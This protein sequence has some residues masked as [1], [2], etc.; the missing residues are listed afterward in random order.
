ME[1]ASEKHVF[2]AYSHLHV[3]IWLWPTQTGFQR[4]PPPHV[5]FDASKT[6]HTLPMWS[7]IQCQPSVQLPKGCHAFHPAQCCRGHHC[8]TSHRGMPKCEC[9]SH[10]VERDSLSEVLIQR[11]VQDLTSRPNI[12]GTKAKNQHSLTSESST[13]MH[14]QIVHPP[15]THATEDTN[16]RRGE[17]IDSVWNKVPIFLLSCLQVE[18][19]VCQ[20][21]LPSRDSQVSFV[22][23]TTNCNSSTLSFIR[24]MV[25]FS[26]ID[27]P[28]ACLRGPV[29]IKMDPH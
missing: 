9:Q 20:P 17:L 26:L 16:T 22:R 23:N 28:T 15:M 10:W 21:W 14:H 12:S 13:R 24:C 6:S 19:R 2:M 18:A 5:C 3:K 4:R 29:M 11:M 1:Q 25:T 7:S 27:S 8:T